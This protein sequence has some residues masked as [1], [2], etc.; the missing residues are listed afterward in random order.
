MARPPGSSHRGRLESFRNVVLSVTA[1][2]V[3]LAG[4]VAVAGSQ[5]APAPAWLETGGNVLEIV[6]VV[7]GV[8]MGILY[9]A[10]LMVRGR[11]A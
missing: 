3:G 7:A 2:V 4:V 6:L 8:A 10:H 5:A 9:L 1:A 11:S